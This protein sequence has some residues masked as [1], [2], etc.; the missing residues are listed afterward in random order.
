MT[1]VTVRGIKRFKDR[2]GHWRCYHRRTGKAIRSEF[3]SGK[4]FLE[5]AALE[6]EVNRPARASNG[7]SAPALY[8]AEERNGLQQAALHASHCRPRRSQLVRSGY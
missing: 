3:G 8:D 4:F 1:Q 5:L 7:I 2:H 6:D